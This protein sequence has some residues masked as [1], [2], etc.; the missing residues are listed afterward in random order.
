MRTSALAAALLTG[1]ALVAACQAIVGISDRTEAAGVDDGGGGDD[2]SSGSTTSSG[3]SSSGASSSGGSSSGASSSG[4]S[5][6]DAADATQPYDV[7]ALAGLKLWL[8]STKEL[9]LASGR[10]DKWADQSGAWEAGAPGAPDGGRHIAEPQDVNAPILVSNGINGRPTLS[11]V[12]GSGYARVANHPDFRFGLGD[13]II[14]EVAKVSSGNGP[15]WELRPNTSAGDQEQFL[16][17][18]LCVYFGGAPGCTAP[19]VTPP[20]GPHVFVGRR[21]GDIFTMRLDG[22]V[23]G[24]LDRTS[25]P[26]DISITEFQKPYA[27]IGNGVTMQ[28]S[29]VII[30]VGPTSD[31]DLTTLENHLKG[32]YGIP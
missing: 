6:T 16:P 18:Q 4:S 23:Q 28:L 9:A 25:D 21:K 12:S 26:V 3:G 32:K 31:A 11:F 20:A 15:L 8:E 19:P 1:S 2:T 17:D 5:G 24:S 13:F 27:F 7:K 22:T 10:L 14:V 29:E 30:V